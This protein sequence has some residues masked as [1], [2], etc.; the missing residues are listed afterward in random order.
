MSGA[1]WPLSMRLYHWVSAAAILTLLALGFVMVNL[2]EA[3]GRRFDLYQ[4][5]K[6]L[7]LFVLALTLVRM[8]WRL[9][10]RAP[11][12]IATMPRWQERAARTMHRALYGLILA[13]GLAGYAMVSTSPLPLPVALP[14]GGHAPNLLA[15]DAGLSEGFKKVHHVLAAILAL[16]IAG[17]VAAALKHHLVDRDDALRRM[18]LFSAQRTRSAID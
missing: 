4:L 16:C 11:A 8:V 17:H 13:L 1:R 18:A 15:P 2:V 5:H 3:P 14:F 9:A 12:P 6:S 7:G 10:R